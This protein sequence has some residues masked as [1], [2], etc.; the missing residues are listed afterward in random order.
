MAS[1]YNKNCIFTGVVDSLCL[2]CQI[3]LKVNDLDRH[4]ESPQ[5]CSNLKSVNYAENFK[6]DLIWKVCFRHFKFKRFRL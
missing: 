3:Y 4:V 5:H 6:E 2:S 1:K